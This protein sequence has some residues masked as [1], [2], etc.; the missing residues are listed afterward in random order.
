MNKNSSN[1][2]LTPDPELLLR[3]IRYVAWAAGV[4]ALAVYGLYFINFSGGLSA[5][6]EK[7]GQFGDFVGGLLNPLFSM[8]ALI[9]LLATFSLQVKEFRIATQQQEETRV[10]LQD[11][12]LA[13]RKQMFESSFFHLMTLHND[14]LNGIDLAGSNGVV[15]GRDCFHVFVRRLNAELPKGSGNISMAVFLD[16]YE[17]FYKGNRREVAHYF[18][19]LYNI[20][21]FI[22]DSDYI[23]KKFYA[24]LIRAQMSTPEVT[25]LFYNCLAPHGEKFKT[26]VEE[27][28]LL[29]GIGTLLERDSTLVSQYGLEAFSGVMPDIE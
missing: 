13:T 15:R 5:S 23:D 14:L 3:R 18:T 28:S 4:C 8:L 22:K 24:N 16:C 26:L 12:Y 6:H 1:S 9:A 7:W 21:K 27:F 25:L 2:D 20:F 19:L 29:K 17:R 10:A 11:Q